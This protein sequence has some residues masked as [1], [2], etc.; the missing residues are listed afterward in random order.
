MTLN[1]LLITSVVVENRPFR[2]V[3]TTYGVCPSWLYELLARYRAEGGAAFEPRSRRPKIVPRTTPAEVID[4]ILELREKLTTTGL[5]AG[6][7]TIRWHLEH[8]HQLVVSRATI[9]RYLTKAGLVT[10]EPKKRPKS[11]YI[12]FEASMPNEYWQSDFTHYPLTRPDS[13]PG[14]DTEILTWLDDC[15]RYALSLTAHHRVTG[16]IVLRTFGETVAEHG[17]PASTLTD[18]EMVFTTRLSQGQEGRR[19]PRQRHPPPCPPRRP[20]PLHRHRPNPRPNP[21]PDPRPGPQHPHHRRRHRRTPP[22]AHPRHIQ[23]LPRHRTTTRPNT[24]T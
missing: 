19:R 7:D 18:N 24:L 2:D 5:D 8:H 22:R 9:S 21:R 3:A 20:A 23:A 11:S 12:G 17:I 10:P 14:A 1:R 13:R 15:S 16:P 4:L 6:P